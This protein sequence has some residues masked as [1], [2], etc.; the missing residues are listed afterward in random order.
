LD[1]SF[2]TGGSV[3]TSFNI[4]SEA[5]SLAL[6]PDGKIIAFGEASQQQGNLQVVF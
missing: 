3:T 4:F 6:Q 5:H 2:G 1:T